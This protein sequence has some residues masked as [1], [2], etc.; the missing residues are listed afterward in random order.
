WAWPVWALGAIALLPQV[1]NR[2]GA[3]AETL[4]GLLTRAPVVA[5]LGAAFLAAVL[6]LAFPDRVRF[7]GDALLRLRTLQVH[8]LIPTAWYPQALPLDLAIH[9]QVASALLHAFAIDA[10][11]PGRLIGAFDAA[12]LAL[13]AA[14]FASALELSG[15]AALACGAIVFWGGA[16]TL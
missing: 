9:H 15:A 6:V 11:T 4:G 7:V 14:A 5:F 10:A 2:L 12:A 3:A 8:G 1:A 13:C 16:L